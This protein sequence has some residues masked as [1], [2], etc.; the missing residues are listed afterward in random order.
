MQKFERQ[1]EILNLSLLPPSKETTRLHILLG[2]SVAMI[3][4]LASGLAFQLGLLVDRVAR[5]LERLAAKYFTFDGQ[6]RPGKQN[7]QKSYILAN[8]VE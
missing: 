6:I 7:R 8:S 2:N 4:G 3:L 5:C 1:K